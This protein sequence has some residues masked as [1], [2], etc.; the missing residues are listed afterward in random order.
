MAT[1]Q[2]HLVL[3]DDGRM[4]TLTLGEWERLQG[5]PVDW[6]ASMPTSQRYSALGDAMNVDMAR[7]LG[8]RLKA[9]HAQIPMLRSA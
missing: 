7:W 2:T 3:H 9:I 8:R 4:R 5:F 1:R 6:T